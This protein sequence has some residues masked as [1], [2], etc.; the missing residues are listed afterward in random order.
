MIDRRRFVQ[1]SMGATL[2]SLVAHTAALAAT[3]PEAT[4]P[5]RLSLYAVVFDERFA[6]ANVFAHVLATHGI[7][8][9]AIRGDVTQ[10]WYSDLNPRWRRDAVPVAGLTMYGPLFCLERLAWDHGMRVIHHGTHP[11]AQEG[12]GWPAQIAAR[13]SRMELPSC[14]RSLSP[15]SPVESPRMTV[16]L[17]SDAPL[18]S[19]IIAPLVRA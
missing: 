1:T 2:A 19:W 14:A 6:A 11:Q 7:P 8:T 4:P 13:L 15:T 5:R 12:G 16:A 18:H 17:G 10:L 9:R 3:V